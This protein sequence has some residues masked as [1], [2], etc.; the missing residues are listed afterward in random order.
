MPVKLRDLPQLHV[1]IRQQRYALGEVCIGAGGLLQVLITVI[2]LTSWLPWFT[3]DALGVELRTE[4]AGLLGWLALCCT[5]ATVWT[6]LALRVL[7]GRLPALPF[8]RSAVPLAFAGIGATCVLIRY[9]FGVSIA[10]TGV[11][12]WNRAFGASLALFSALVVL[13]GAISELL[14]DPDPFITD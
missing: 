2:G 4:G 8:K 11:A 13:A 6:V 1:E 9:T 12:E 7:R 3:L 14:R 10:T 5:L